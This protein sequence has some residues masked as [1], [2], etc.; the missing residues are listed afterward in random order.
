MIA[1][2]V[3]LILSSQLHWFEGMKL[4]VAMLLL[5]PAAGIAT[6]II[7]GIIYN[8]R[9]KK[10]LS[11][12]I[13]RKKELAALIVVPIILIGI[14]LFPIFL[15]AT[16][17][18]KPAQ[19][20]HFSDAMGRFFYSSSE[21]DKPNDNIFGE[22]G[23]QKLFD[24]DKTTCWAEGVK[25]PGIGEYVY[26]D[27]PKKAFAVSILN[28]YQKSEKTFEANNRAKQIK[29]TLYCL[30]PP[31]EKEVTELVTPMKIKKRSFYI[32]RTLK[33]AEESQKINFPAEWKK[34]INKDWKTALKFELLSVYKGAK[35]DDTCVSEISFLIPELST[36]KTEMELWLK[37]PSGKRKIYKSPD[38]VL[39]I[40]AQEGDWAILIKM[41]REV[42]GRAATEYS[43]F[44]IP[45]KKEID[46]SRTGHNVGGI[47]GFDK[48]GD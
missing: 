31:N 10:I 41:P 18:L 5:M 15:T 37:G 45:M 14:T 25:G 2:A 28:G 23:D 42:A 21:L 11:G 30:F 34:A 46:L 19:K 20:I 47:Y 33:D 38:S 26:L 7:M 16:A 29:L 9:L 36:D 8:K 35:Y 39:Q 48:Y 17:A 24:H 43:L 44:N 27:I 1:L 6:A 22:Y 4:M 32:I 12:E 13:T 3:I 40:V